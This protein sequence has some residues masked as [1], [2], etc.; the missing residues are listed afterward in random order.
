L[1]SR[2]GT[3]QV[4]I[5]VRVM[6]YWVIAGLMATAMMLFTAFQTR[7][8]FMLRGQEMSYLDT[9]LW[10]GV[11]WYIW[12]LLAPLAII[13]TMRH[14]IE[15]GPGIVRTVALHVVFAAGFIGLH[16][17]L[18]AAVMHIY[19]ERFGILPE[20]GP[21]ILQLLAMQGHWG[22]MSYIA[23][24]AMVHVGIYFRRAQR[25]ALAR[26]ELRTQA[27]SAQLTALARQMQPHFL[28]NALNALV[29]MLEEGSTAQVFTIRLA[30]MLRIL[31]QSGD[32][33][34]AT[35][36]EELAL[37]EAYLEIER[38]RLG[39]RLSTD[40]QVSPAVTQC[41]LPAFILQPLV[42]NAITHGIARTLEGGEIQVR[43]QRDADDVV[44]DISNT[45]AP[46]A[47]GQ[48]PAD[49]MQLTIPNCR[50]RLALMY[51][52]HARFEAGFVTRNLFRASII[53]PRDS[54]ALAQPT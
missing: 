38:A 31:L 47:A 48:E 52:A 18:A 3:E 37:V 1:A 44:I 45:C 40:I 42:E 10:S 35:L 29:A 53:L 32:R 25:E 51:G 13:L 14:P 23:L 39:S 46:S 54:A 24:V 21:S 30:D 16:A 7:L 28:F 15:K 4:P 49:G 17:V 41:R 8:Q 20:F 11:I 33:A 50:R 19:P 22:F 6:R 36:G 43:A 2:R 34:T 12:A 26:E 9:M 5:F 27:A